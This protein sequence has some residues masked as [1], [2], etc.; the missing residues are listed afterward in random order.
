[1][2]MPIKKYKIVQETRGPLERGKFFH[3]RSESIEW[4]RLRKYAKAYHV[5]VHTRTVNTLHYSSSVRIARPSECTG[6]N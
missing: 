3:T 2:P 4:N 5:C 6:V 1:M